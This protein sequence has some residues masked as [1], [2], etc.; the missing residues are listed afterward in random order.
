MISVIY[1]KKGS[2]KTKRII[3]AANEAASTADGQILFIT[4][5]DH[6]LGIKPSIRFVNITEYDVKSEEEFIGFVKG[7]LATNFDIQKVYVDGISRLL[8]LPADDI[9]P[10]FEVLEKFAKDVDFVTT[11]SADE[12]PTYLKKYAVKD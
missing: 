4:D 2:G 11:V 3:D 12:L 10:V 5:D 8:D 1:G 9:K 6:S 7:M